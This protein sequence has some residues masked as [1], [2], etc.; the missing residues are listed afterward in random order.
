MKRKILILLLALCLCINSFSAISASAATNYLSYTISGEE[1]TVTRCS[2]S[3]NGTVDVPATFNGY[4]VTKIGDG[5]FKECTKLDRVTLP[6]TVTSIGAEAFYGCGQLFA[7][8]GTGNIT[9]IADK[10]FKSCSNLTYFTIPNNIEYIGKYAFADTNLGSI[11]LPERAITIGSN[12]FE[13]SQYADNTANWT[14]GL[15]Y[16]GK[17]LVK[18]DYFMTETANIAEGTITIADGAF[19]GCYQMKGVTFPDGLIRIGDSAFAWCHKIEKAIIPES[20]TY[21]GSMAF[22]NCYALTQANIPGKVKNISDSTFLNCSALKDVTISEGVTSIGSR[23][24]EGCRLFGEI[25]IPASLTSVGVDAFKI[26]TDLK[27][28]NI[29]DLS[30]WCNISFGN[31]TANPA[32][33]AGGLYLGGELIA[34]LKIPAGVQVIKAYAFA[35][36]TAL[37]EIVIPVSVTNIKK[38]AFDGCSNISAVYYEGSSEQWAGVAVGSDN[39]NF[40]NVVAN[41]LVF[42]A[43]ENTYSF[44]T[45]SDQT[46]PDAIGYRLMSAPNLLEEDRMFVG[47]YD[48]AELSGEAITLPYYGNATTL[49]GKWREKN[50]T[51]FDEAITT[52]LNDDYSVTTQPGGMT[53]YKFKPAETREYRI[54]SSGGTGVNAQL[55]NADKELITASTGGS[56]FCITYNLTAGNTY[57]IAM[58]TGEVTADFNMHIRTNLCIYRFVNDDGTVVI[59]N[60]APFGSVLLS[61]PAGPVKPATQQYA[62]TFAGWEG[63][64]DGITITRDVTFTATYNATIN[65]Y[66]Y[67]FV[68]EDGRLIS[69]MTADYGT[70]IEAPASPVKEE[71]EMYTYAFAY[72]NG[73][74]E[75]MTLTDNVIFKAVYTQSIK[76]YTVTFVSD[77]EVVCSYVADHGSVIVLPATP[78]KPATQQYSYIFTGWEGYAADM[79]AKGNVTFTAV[80]NQVLN[81]YTYKFVDEDGRVIDE[82]TACYGTIIDTAPEDPVKAATQQYTYYFIGWEGYSASMALVDN[83]TFTAKYVAK[84]NQYTYRFVE[85]DGTFIAESTVDYG[86]KIELPANPT[87]PATAEHTYFFAGWDGYQA[88]MTVTDNIT[89]TAIYTS[90]IN[91]YTYKFTDE[92]G[93]VLLEKTVNYGTKI[94]VPKTPAKAATQQYT[95]TFDKWIGYETGMTATE[96]KTFVASYK[97]TVNKYTYKFVDESGYTVASETVDYGTVIVSPPAD[98]SK[99]A[100]Q[101]YTYTFAG[102]EGYREGM[103]VT[104]DVT[105]R[106]IFNATVNKYTY[107]FVNYDGAVI[108]EARVDYGTEIIAPANPTKAETAQYY[109]IFAGWEGFYEGAILTDNVTFTAQYTTHIQRY[110]YTFV[111]D[112]TVV[113][114]NTAD[115]GTIIDTAPEDP[116]KAAT[117]QYTYTFDYWNGYSP[118]MVLDRNQTFE[119]VYIVTVNQYTCKFFDEE[120]NLF[121][122]STM[123]YGTVITPPEIPYKEYTTYMGWEGYTDGMQLTE[124]I[125]FQMVYKFEEHTITV[126]GTDVSVTAEYSKYYYIEPVVKEGYM[127][128][129]YFDTPD[130]TGHKLLSRNGYSYEPYLFTSDMTVYPYYIPEEFPNGIGTG[131]FVRFV[132]TSQKHMEGVIGSTNKIAQS[133]EFVVDEPELTTVYLTLRFPDSLKLAGDGKVKA[134]RGFILKEHGEPVKCEDGYTEISL[135]MMCDGGGINT[136]GLSL[137][138]TLEFVL[139]EA[140]QEGVADIS[141]KDM[142]FTDE[143]HYGGNKVYYIRESYP[144]Y[145]KICRESVETVEKIEIIGDDRVAVETAYTIQATP[146]YINDLEVRE[147]SVSD[148]TIATID[149]YTGILTPKK[150]GTV[151]V[152]AQAVADGRMRKK[153]IEIV[154][155]TYLT[156]LSSDA[157]MWAD[158]FKSGRCEYDIYVD[159]STN[160][161]N[162]TPVF[163]DE[164][165]VYLGGGESVE[166]GKVITIPLTQKLTTVTLQCYH[167]DGVRGRKYTITILKGNGIHCHYDVS[168]NT[169]TEL[170][171]MVP[172]ATPDSVVIVAYMKKGNLVDFEKRAYTGDT[173]HFEKKVTGSKSEHDSLLILVW[174]KLDRPQPVFRAVRVSFKFDDIY[175]PFDSG[176]V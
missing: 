150:T 169:K 83:V 101:Q 162:F 133:I 137:L 170:D 71:S 132:C 33:N 65:Q 55:Y 63:Y 135:K 76:Q 146:N 17:H 11:T 38:Y 145:I 159:E 140:A 77:G 49:Y 119:A 54:Y 40:N 171:V 18:A 25:T 36:N 87:K 19:D 124:D 78:V 167:T 134:A 90:E 161:I 113:Y 152:Y 59:E 15:L 110:T 35:G 149:R 173:M 42:N 47:W 138:T 93:K 107:K 8:E 27:K 123:D 164:C 13:G 52:Q 126:A 143:Y 129:G 158:A 9:Y 43:K 73:Y 109:Y 165:V 97:V 32:R 23:A 95:Y 98:L 147:W 92:D 130:F 72:W 7:V 48:N 31:E 10:A 80:F 154:E 37:D 51:S 104:E 141:V 58:S 21:L 44:V 94:E 114:E 99:P 118:N 111:N 62:Y 34:Q 121:S 84:V 103:S 120:G 6:S 24:F 122:E 115:Y 174:R 155:P 139:T 39:G 45:N 4:P 166:S 66:T 163:G 29:T 91:K 131:S 105:F 75:G 128:M 168:R 136:R 41:S 160:V 156:S 88:D 112:G 53:Y 28:V 61:A 127:L 60:N 74:T 176:K 117:Q 56:D 89:F 125:S 108:S 172:G 70:L 153:T 157:G 175:D 2:T 102:W 86:T 16:I 79:V 5:A 12:A 67:Q 142:Y 57:Y 144:Q 69:E 68:D 3:A 22:Y 151:T 64:T 116:V 148:T 106:A 30:T 100:T 26:C 85:E 20:V 81:Q 50:G 1:V 14:G 96:N 82:Q 46:V